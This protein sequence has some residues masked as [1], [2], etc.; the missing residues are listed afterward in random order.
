M[1]KVEPPEGWTSP[2]DHH[3]L[4]DADT[5]R[6]PESLVSESAIHSRSR[7]MDNTF[8]DAAD[9]LAGKQV[10]ASKSANAEPP[11]TS[12][13]PPESNDAP[14]LPNADWTS[15]SSRKKLVIAAAIAVALLLGTGVIAIGRALVTDDSKTEEVAS[16]DVETSEPIAETNDAPAADSDVQPPQLPNDSGD[17][18]KA[19]DVRNDQTKFVEDAG[20]DT[21]DIIEPSLVTPPPKDPGDK[22]DHS[23]PETPVGPPGLVDKS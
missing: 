8:D 18:D 1:V 10:P 7:P 23:S 20:N 5:R 6:T 16:N 11:R 19:S 3:A 14:L 9:M 2:D 12:E 22:V 13:K 21:P 17:E 4:D 15:G